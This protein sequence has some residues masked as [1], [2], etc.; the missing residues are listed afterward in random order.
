MRLSGQVHD[1]GDAVALHYVKDRGLVPQI[2]LLEEVLGMLGD[3]GQI[4]EAPGIGQ[5]IEVNQLDYLG[6]VNDMLNEIRADESGPASDL[7]VHC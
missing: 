6:P 5:A 3:A 2:C 1:V 7:E 4:F